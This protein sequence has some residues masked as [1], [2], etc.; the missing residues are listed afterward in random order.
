MS[1]D[2]VSPG[3][4][5]L[6]VSEDDY[7]WF[8]DLALREMVAIVRFLG[9]DEAN[10]RPDVAGANSP[11]AIL[12]HC[13]GVMEFWGGSMVAERV[14]SRDRQAE[15]EAVGTVDDLIERT[16]TARRQFETDVSGFDSTAASPMILPP[17]DAETPYARTKGAVLLHVLEELLQHLG[18]MELSRDMLR[19]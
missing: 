12:T 6:A 14:I 15:F 7:L 5:W 1:A 9:D 3:A 19:S 16:A 2:P 8:V 17:E 11:Y 4:A 13:L 10:R 18:Q